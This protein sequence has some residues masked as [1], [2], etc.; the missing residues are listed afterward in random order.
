LR[1][2]YISPHLDDAI[3]SC[4]GLIREQVLSK[5]PVEIWT[6]FAGDPPEG[7]PSP[8]A[9]SQYTKWGTGMDAYTLRRN[10][11]ITACRLVGAR[12][13]HLPFQDCIY[14]RSRDG[15]WLYPSEQSIFGKLAMDD[16]PNIYALQT[17]IATIL[18]PDDVMMIPL[19]IGKHVDHQLVRAGLNGLGRQLHY[20]AEVP[21]LFE[22]PDQVMEETQ[23]LQPNLYPFSLQAL[24]SWQEAIQAYRS[25]VDVLFESV[26]I[27]REKTGSYYQ[28]D[29]G[30]R[31]WSHITG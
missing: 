5:K 22:N 3:L 27:M 7:E 1:W 30:I 24:V 21:Y 12:Y 6:I 28:T 13:R 9:I 8:F 15:S 25:Q 23:D 29:K 17:F 2:I 31:L 20:Y 4:G 26:E 14:R 19:T 16:A 10:E 18:K 11:D